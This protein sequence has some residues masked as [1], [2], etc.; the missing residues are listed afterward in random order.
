[1]GKK[2]V[3][4][5]VCW[6]LAGVIVFACIDSVKLVFQE[7][8]D[9]LEAME[10]PEEGTPVTVDV[11][12]VIDWFATLEHQ[13]NGVTTSTEYYCIVWLDDSKFISMAVRESDKDTVDDIID[14]T[15]EYLDGDAES[16]PVPTQFTGTLTKM[17]TEEQDYFED[18]LMDMGYTSDEI[19]QYAYLWTVDTT[20]TKQMG[21]IALGIAGVLFIIGLIFLILGIRAG[22]KEKA[23][24][25]QNVVETYNGNPQNYAYY[26]PEN[27]GTNQDSMGYYN[28]DASNQNQGTG[29]DNNGYYDGGSNTGA[30]TDAGN[31]YCDGNDNNQ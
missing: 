11:D 7:P 28:G 23:A 30:G 26:N 2:I 18:Y 9:I 14:D 20:N 19:P 25:V 5:I 13:R 21:L 8:V 12:A 16:Y 22:K 17:Q 3:Y 6:I 4:T 27:Y 29:Y 31:G 1:M 24:P 10:N 15:W